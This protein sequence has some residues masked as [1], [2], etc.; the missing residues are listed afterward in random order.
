MIGRNAFLMTFLLSTG[1][2]AQSATSSPQS[3][4][5]RG[6]VTSA[7]GQVLG[8]AVVSL[9]ALETQQ[10]ANEQGKFFFANVRPGTYR[11]TVRQLGYTAANVEVHVVAGQIQD[12]AVKMDHIVNTLTAMK[13]KGQWA[14]AN[15]GRPLRTGPDPLVEVF[16]QLEQNAVRLR[17]LSTQYP[18]DMITERRRMMQHADGLETLDN[19]DSVRTSSS[20]KARYEPGKVVHDPEGVTKTRE[21]LLQI[22]TLLDFADPQFQSNHCFVLAGVEENDGVKEIR[23]EFKPADKLKTP[24]VGGSVFLQAETFKLTRSEIDLTKIPSNLPGLMRVR[25]TTYFDEVFPGL[26]IIGEVVATSDLKVS[27]PLAPARA[28]ERIRTLRLVFLK[29]APGDSIDTRNDRLTSSR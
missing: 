2:G 11:L 27:S 15:P 23:V 20:T 14:C 29:S 22:P 3:G 12:V 6:S 9:T 19:L 21:K 18:F 25:A 13:V 5:L 7:T 28:V 17:L 4:A 26:P 16:E 8:Y 1:L 24:D 10:F